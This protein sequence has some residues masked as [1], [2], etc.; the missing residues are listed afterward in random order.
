MA[1]EFTG[2]V[3]FKDSNGNVVF[4]IDP[5]SNLVQVLHV[6]PTGQ[7]VMELTNTGSISLLG[8]G[9][10]GGAQLDGTAGRLTP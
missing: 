8:S 7:Q 10:D 3:D 4:T 9:D 6:T 1:E 2:R 5:D